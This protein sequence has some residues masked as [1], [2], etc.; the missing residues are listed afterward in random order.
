ML[1]T[2]SFSDGSLSTSQGFFS[3]GSIEKKGPVGPF[4]FVA[5]LPHAVL[6]IAVGGFVNCYA[7]NSNSNLL[8]RRTYAAYA[9]GSAPSLSTPATNTSGRAIRVNL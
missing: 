7:D 2:S 4:G 1:A 5:M 9:P 3:D 8:S 6:F